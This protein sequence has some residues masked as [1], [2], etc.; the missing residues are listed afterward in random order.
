VKVT[1]QIAMKTGGFQLMFFGAAGQGYE[2][3]AS[4]DLTVPQSAWRVVGTGTF[5]GT[6]DTFTDTGSAGYSHRYYV[7]KSP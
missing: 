4:D 3:L 1:K 5:S 7:V 2:V 6:N